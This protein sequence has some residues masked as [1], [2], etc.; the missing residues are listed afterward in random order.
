MDVIREIVQQYFPNRTVDF[1]SFGN[2][3]IND[4]YKLTVN[5]KSEFILQKINTAVFTSPKEI[6]KNYA[7][8]LNLLSTKDDF[9]IPNLVKTNEGENF[10]LDSRG[11]F[12]RM[13]SFVKNSYS[14]EVVQNTNQAFQAGLGFG[15]FVY[16]FAKC[17]STKFTEAIPNFHSLSF[18]LDQ[19]DE[20]IQNNKSGRNEEARNLIDFYSAREEKLK[21]IESLIKKDFIPTRVVHNDTKI[22][23]LLFCDE[24]AISVIDLDT[25]G[26]GSVLYDFGDSIRTIANEAAE[27]EQDLTKVKF[28]LNFYESF[29]KAYLSY[30]SQILVEEEIKNLCVAPIYMTY[31]MG[32][33][34]LADFLNGDLYY[35]TKYDKH[36]FV[37]SSVQK[38]LI[39]EMES[40]HAEMKQIIHDNK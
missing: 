38:R 31:I 16:K 35:K 33:R 14:I 32:I 40:K 19:L 8:L 17:E 6:I 1:K 20:A 26:P 7:R 5:E 21:Q 34:F 12:W 25:V 39:E 28:N 9:L 37:R 27:D 4:T 10:L 13:T 24:K 15:W 23:N 22:N 3:H 36:N 29:T 18:R 2:G 30:T 11:G